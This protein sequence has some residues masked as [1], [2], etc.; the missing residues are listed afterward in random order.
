MDV[1]AG[2]LLRNG[3]IRN[4]LDIGLPETRNRDNAELA[5]TLGNHLAAVPTDKIGQ[6]MHTVCSSLPAVQSGNRRSKN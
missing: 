1:C 6:Y 2:R 4:H 5:M 3:T